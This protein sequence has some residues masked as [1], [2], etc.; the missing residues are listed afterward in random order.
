MKLTTRK[1]SRMKAPA[2]TKVLFADVLLEQMARG[3][4]RDFEGHL[5]SV[6]LGKPDTYGIYTPTLTR[7]AIDVFPA[8]LLRDMADLLAERVGDT[9]PEVGEWSH[10]HCDELP[11]GVH[12]LDGD[13]WEDDAVKAVVAARRYLDDQPQ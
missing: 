4:L 12:R 10:A 5:I 9:R 8:L 1:R 2:G 11:N 3:T 13:W 6:A 7:H